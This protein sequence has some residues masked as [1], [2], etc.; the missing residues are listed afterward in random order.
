MYF[1]DF[2]R[3]TKLRRGSGLV[4]VTAGLV[5]FIFVLLL[6]LDLYIILQGAIIN[7]T[8]V[9][10]LARTASKGPPAKLTVGR[11]RVVTER[12]APYERVMDLLQKKKEVL[13]AWYELSPTINITET[14]NSPIPV[15][16]FGGPVY[17]TVTVETTILVHLQFAPGFFKMEP[18]SLTASK[19]FPY[20]WVMKSQ[21]VL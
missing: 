8:L 19:T 18:I 5:L 3:I 21:T 10:D 13:P 16:P 4:E 2:M 7:D 1:T 17:G 6:A 15:A 14:I 11:G 9:R 20:T 12:T